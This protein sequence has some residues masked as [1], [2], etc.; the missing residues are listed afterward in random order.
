[1]CTL[2]W[3]IWQGKL[4]LAFSRDEALD[5]AIAEPP[6]IEQTANGKIVCPVDPEGG[7]TWL[8]LNEQGL[9]LCLLNDYRYKP[10]VARRSRGLLVKDLANSHSLEDL[11]VTLK[12]LNLTDYAP[13]QLV[14]FPGPEAPR[15]WQWNGSDLAEVV[16]PGSPLSSSSLFP[17]LT[18]WLRRRWFRRQTGGN[19]RQLTAEQHRQL[20]LNS[21]PL[22]RYLGIRM[23][24]S[25]RATVSLC[26]LE[27]TAHEGKLH[28]QDLL[29]EKQSTT[30][31]DIQSRSIRQ[32]DQPVQ[33]DRPLDLEALF[34]S[35]NPALHQSL[36]KLTWPLLRWVLCEAKL[37]RGLSQ[38]DGQHARDF[39]AHVL[40]H[41]DVS[42][43]I[44]ANSAPLPDASKRPVFLA[45]HP[46]GGIDGLV[47][48]TW[49]SQH[50]P[51]LR[52]IVSDALL[53][54]P[55]L[56]P[57]VVP[58]DRYQ[59]NH[60]ALRQLHKAFASDAALLIFPAGRTARRQQGRLVDAPWQKMP[61]NLARQYERSLVT[62]HLDTANS[63]K[64]DALAAV[65]RR[66]SIG[67]N[68]EMLLLVRE[69]LKPARRT[70]GLRLGP[71]Q[72]AT[73]WVPKGQTDQARLAY[74][75]GQY[76]QLAG[77]V[78]PALSSTEVFS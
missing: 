18:P 49:L 45:N 40:D 44:A 62:L 25:Q 43:R 63:W 58:V 72:T 20:H 11:A 37:N 38:L 73:E 33:R 52:V 64:F 31:L 29:N 71:Y 57:F 26:H 23:R 75:R 74:W 27:L 67:L 42:I 54:L 66:L 53:A 34:Q 32:G 69:I 14:V 56:E 35:K 8:S 7:G 41:L 46:S 30:R 13:F 36:P 39:C 5:R 47:L 60:G 21:G 59:R 48:I 6:R 9:V 4:S 24:R 22:G 50:F 28:Y 68:L 77:P 61:I 65:R 10:S 76:D 15:L 55:H 16:A 19:L 78:E 3:Q 17:A 51:E 12:Q 2:S 1:M 70:V